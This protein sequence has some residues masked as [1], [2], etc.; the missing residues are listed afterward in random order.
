M[1]LTSLYMGASANAN[2]SVSRYE[3]LLGLRGDQTQ[4]TSSHFRFQFGNL[5]FGKYKKKTDNLSYYNT[6]L[7]VKENCNF[8]YT[9]LKPELIGGGSNLKKS[10]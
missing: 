4:E 6:N 5:K 3:Y 1:K 9:G 10:D 8:R 7:F 2:A